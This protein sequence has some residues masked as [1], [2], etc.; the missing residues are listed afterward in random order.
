[1]DMNHSVKLLYMHRGNK[2]LLLRFMSPLD[3]SL[4][5]RSVGPHCE[6]HGL[7]FRVS[8]LQFSPHPGEL[9][10]SPPASTQA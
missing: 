6:D 1:M 4:V 7:T 5:C 9:Y 10:H 3:H 2:S 8:K